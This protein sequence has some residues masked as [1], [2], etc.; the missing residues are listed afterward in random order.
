MVPSSD[1]LGIDP[2]HTQMAS[3][4]AIENGV[5]LLRSTRWGLT[6]AYDPYARARAW[7]S[8][9]DASDGVVV[10]S[11]PRAGVP[12]LYTRI[13]DGFAALCAA[14]AVTAVIAS[15]LRR[16]GSRLAPARAA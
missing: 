10:A 13:G 16:R 2:I 12:T 11:L 15:R 9:F 4:R 8:S 1:W 14:F 7:Q 6:A 3:V 5:S